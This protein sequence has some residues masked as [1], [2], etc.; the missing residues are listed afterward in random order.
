VRSLLT[1]RQFLETGLAGSFAGL[2]GSFGGVLAARR[3]PA[4][5][6]QI[7]ERADA[8]SLH[9]RLAAHEGL[10]YAVIFDERFAEARRF[11]GIARQRGVR[12]RGVRGDVT[13]LW[14][15]E[16]RP[17][18]SRGAAAIAGV[19]AYGALF[20]LERLAWD[21]RMRVVHHGIHTDVANRPTLHSWV[22]ALPARA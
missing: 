1:R 3:V 15:H 4:D 20:C 13:D 5:A 21:H 9:A 7:C 19:T 10:L 11:A 6:S 18:W 8:A 17:L 14:Y 2:A 12:T 22:I 16:L